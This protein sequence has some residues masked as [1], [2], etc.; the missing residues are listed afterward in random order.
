ME[1][2]SDEQNLEDIRL[3]G[4]ALSLSLTV[5]DI[6]RSLSWYC[7]VLGFAMR[8]NYEREG[9]LRAV[10]LTSG[11]VRILITQD[12]GTRAANRVKGEGFSIKIT[13]TQNIDLLAEAIKSRGGTLENEPID[14]RWGQRVF[15]LRDPDGYKFAISSEVS[16]RNV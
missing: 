3:V 14:L 15:R 7:D 5:S 2:Q 16:E 6:K 12:E 11:E 1:T 8:R 4:R 13:S 9:R 10:S